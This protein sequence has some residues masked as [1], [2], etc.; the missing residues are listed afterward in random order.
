MKTI[1]YGLTAVVLAALSAGCA[2]TERTQAVAAPGAEY[3]GDRYYSAP[4]TAYVYTSPSPSY[5]VRTY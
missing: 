2:Y 5:V 1:V 4:S 3:Y